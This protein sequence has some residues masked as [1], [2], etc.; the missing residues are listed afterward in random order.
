M[1]LMTPA[2]DPAASQPESL[3]IAAITPLLLQLSSVNLCVGI[4]QQFLL[5]PVR[6]HPEPQACRVRMPTLHSLTEGTK[7]GPER[8]TVAVLPVGRHVESGHSHPGSVS[9]G[10]W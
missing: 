5:I 6:I 9:C 1:H 2:N 4:L 7:D 10:T 8:T 3:R